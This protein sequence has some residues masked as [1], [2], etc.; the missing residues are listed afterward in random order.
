LVTGG[1]RGVG[2]AIVERLTRDG[3]EV[4]FGFRE[5]R[6][7]ADEVVAATGGR[8]RAFQVDLRD[9]VDLR[10][11]FDDAERAL[12]ELHILVNNAA[13][14][15]RL[16]FG[17][18]AE[19]QYDE[20]MSL[21]TKATFFAIQEAVRRMD[22]GGRIINVSSTATVLAN[23]AQ[24]VYCASKAAVEQMTR[25][26]ARALAGRGIMVN[27]VSPGAIETE[28]SLAGS[29]PEAVAQWRRPTAFGRLGL[30]A[31]VADVVAFLAG[32]DARWLTGQNLRAAGGAV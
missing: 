30:P 16:A 31:D 27:T 13:V 25:V 21:N 11:F 7:A 4:V 9:L 20:V 29:S 24:A 1:S 5:R 22:S 18:T 19:D 23:P 3:A 6:A 12:G 15:H 2:R 32:P 28:S 17:D 8:A 14:M 26:A 10:R